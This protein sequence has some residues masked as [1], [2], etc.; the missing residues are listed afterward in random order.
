MRIKQ[1]WRVLIGK[2]EAVD[3]VTVESASDPILL[4]PDPT[5]RFNVF[6]VHLGRLVVSDAQKY[7]GN[8]ITT[9]VKAFNYYK[10]S[11]WSGTVYLF[12]GEYC[13]EKETR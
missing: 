13:L 2:A 9:A 10:E 6:R 4:R 12:D 1:A 5:A 3:K 8:R 11:A 7:S